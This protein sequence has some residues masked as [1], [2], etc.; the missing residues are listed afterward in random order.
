MQR[1]GKGLCLVPVGTPMVCAIAVFESSGRVSIFTMCSCYWFPA[2]NQ[3]R[4]TM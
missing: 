1:N 2:I 3:R 4:A